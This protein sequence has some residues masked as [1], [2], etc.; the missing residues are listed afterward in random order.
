M[1]TKNIIHLVLLAALWG[2]SFLFMRIAVPEFGAI[3]LI[4]L[5]V[6]LA[7]LVLLPLWWVREA[8]VTK[9]KLA[10]LWREILVIGA[11]N[12]A[13]PFVLFAYSMHY[14][15]GGMAA[16]LNGTAPIWGAIVAWVW[17]RE[18][19]TAGAVLGL[20]VGFLGVIILVSDDISLSLTGKTLGILASASAPILYG[21]A[22]NYTTQKL[23]ELSPLTIATFTMLSAAILLLIPSI[24]QIPE[25]NPSLDAWYALIAL[26]VLC[27]AFAYLLFFGLLSNVGS[28]KAWH[29]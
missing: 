4:E 11:L 17:L 9:T 15:S 23:H 8:A 25:A 13:I 16:T 1:S 27:T 18:G 28:T 26:A 3:V 7:G 2:A 24:A 12:S 5:R 10:E 14:I 20:F 19:L 6:L 22:A 21:I 29:F